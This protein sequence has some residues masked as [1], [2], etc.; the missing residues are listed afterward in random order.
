[1]STSS[2]IW[3]TMHARHRLEEEL[4]ALMSRRDVGTGD[5]ADRSDQV[6]DA[7]LARKNR[8]R[9]IHDLLSKA[10]VGINPPDDGLAEPGMV[11]TVRYDDTGDIE[12]FLLGARGAEDTDIEVY[13]VHSPLGSA[14]AGALPGE[15]RSYP[16]PSG[17]V[18][19]V[20][21][22]SAKPFGA[23]AVDAGAQAAA[24]V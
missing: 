22:L 10:E 9:Q 16:L 14:L 5:D 17:A 4:A 19:P 24:H 21:L 11:L 15:Q 12:T 8:I 23:H 13:S 2:R 20:T 7:W 6:I 3:M 1:M 18:Q